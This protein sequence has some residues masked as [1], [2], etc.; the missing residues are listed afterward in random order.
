MATNV[1]INKKRLSILMHWISCLFVS[2]VRQV[3]CIKY[4]ENIYVVELADKLR[5][6]SFK[7]DDIFGYVLQC[8][9]TYKLCLVDFAT[10]DYKISSTL[11]KS[12]PQL[13]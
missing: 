1:P 2:R 8:R 4:M 9:L 10:S 5:N 3:E 11:H 7:L 6:T 12:V 13:Y